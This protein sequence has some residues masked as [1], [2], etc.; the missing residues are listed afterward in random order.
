MI[1][2]E[3]DINMGDYERKLAQALL[4]DALYTY[5]FDVTTGVIEHDVVSK[6]GFNYT[7]ALGLTSPCDFDEMTRRSFE[8][9]RINRNFVRR[10]YKGLGVGQK[11]SR[12]KG[13]F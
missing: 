5:T 6:N 4:K 12:D 1:T 7:K 10:A 8:C 9:K 13:L 3:K 2:K 11:K